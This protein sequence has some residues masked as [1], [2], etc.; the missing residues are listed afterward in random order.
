MTDNWMFEAL[1]LLLF[2]YFR[3]KRFYFISNP[4]LHFV[5]GNI[6]T[7]NIRY[8]ER[9]HIHEKFSLLLII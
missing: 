8:S 4:D 6:F 7:D 1:L 2:L 9:N 3:L 5:K